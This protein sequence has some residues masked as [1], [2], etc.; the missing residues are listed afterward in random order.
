MKAIV[1]GV[2]KRFINPGLKIV[3][4]IIKCLTSQNIDNTDPYLI[5]KFDMH[6]FHHR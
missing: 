2:T 6:V 1:Y 4:E 3:F 5:F